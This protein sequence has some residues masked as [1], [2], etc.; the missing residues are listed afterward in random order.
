MGNSLRCIS[1]DQEQNQ[2]K[3]TVVNGGGESSNSEK[4]VRRL[5][6]IP[7]FRRRTLLPSLSCAGSSTSGSSTSKKGG[8]KTKKKIRERHHQEHHHHDNEKDSRIQE[9]TL[10]A[11]NV[12]F[13]QTP[14]NSNSAPPFRRST[15]VVYPSSQPPPSAVAAVTGSVSG[16][17]TPK[18]STCGFVRSSS[19]RQRSSTDPELKVEGADTKRFVLV[20]GGGFGAWCWYKT[21]T[22]LEK[23]GFQVDAVDLTGS[24]VSSF[25]TNN[26][27]SLA[28]YVKP[29]LHFFDTLK[30][31][32]KVILVGHDFGGACM[33]YAMEMFP[34]K[35]SKAV[36]IS[37]AMLANGQSTLDLFNQQPES[38]HDLMEQ[39]HL[40]LYA[41]GKKSSPTA[42]DFDRS[43]LRDF[44]FNQ[45]PPKDVEVIDDWEEEEYEVE[46]KLG[47][48][49]D[50]GGVV[51]RGVPWGERVLSI[52]SQVLKESEKDLQLFAF[53]TSPRGYVYIRLDKP[54][55][56]YGCPSMDE[57]EE[58][59]REYKKRLDDAGDAQVVPE[60]LALEVSSPGAERLL[61]VPE[62]LHR[63]KEMPMTVSYEEEA[64]SRK[65]VKST[66][67]LLESVDAESEICI[68]K[69]A[70]VRENRDPESKGRP[71]SRKQ[72]DLRFKLPFSVHMMITLYL[73]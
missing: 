16:V 52:A 63:F 47:D 53:R 29:L 56:E 71:L 43:L 8:V 33:S 3:P 22:L 12:L 41:N 72:K 42:V 55:H 44:F 45:S 34:S 73:D 37:A 62:D 31:T 57:L 46:A 36:F 70:D 40:F 10:A 6:L 32:E 13:S 39:V 61:K 24:G 59:S 58:F 14:R 67:L 68:W 48:G 7:S 23:H 50:G 1:Q 27:T 17:L 19:N 65:T 69:L 51:L 18:K 9:Q 25:D 64:N 35:I 5:S 38:S 49:G 20:H 4:H 11:T 26:I 30:P 60:D 15:S 2:K 28:Q 54:S 66:V 21:I